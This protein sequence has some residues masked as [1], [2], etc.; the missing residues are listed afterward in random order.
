MTRFDQTWRW[1]GMSWDVDRKP[2]RAANR[3]S[4]YELRSW[5][6]QI[7]GDGGFRRPMTNGFIG[8]TIRGRTIQLAQEDARP[9]NTSLLRSRNAQPLLQADRWTSCECEEGRFVDRN[10][11]AMDRSP[12]SSWVLKRK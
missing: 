12:R 2:R 4:A 3:W 9:R 7:N 1:Q 10:F 6:L 11:L 5:M 8:S